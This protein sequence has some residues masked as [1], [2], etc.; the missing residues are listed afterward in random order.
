MS[1]YTLIKSSDGARGDYGWNFYHSLEEG[2][3]D[4]AYTKIYS[5]DQNIA[6]LIS[7]S[8]LVGSKNPYESSDQKEGI[9]EYNVTCRDD[10]YN[11][12][13]I[14]KATFYIP[15]N[16]LEN[17]SYSYMYNMFPQ[18]ITVPKTEQYRVMICTT[19]NNI[20]KSIIMFQLLLKKRDS[21]EDSEEED[22]KEDSKEDS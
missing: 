3:Y 12:H 8:T 16:D 4:L 22:S 19:D 21:E 20:D 18:S 5:T 17:N 13:R 9:T 6:C 1:K 2:T 15:G 7:F 10:L 11:L 14:E